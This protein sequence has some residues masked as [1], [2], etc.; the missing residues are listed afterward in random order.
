MLEEGP[1]IN[2]FSWIQLLQL[3]IAFVPDC[4]PT[5]LVPL[6]LQSYGRYPFP[7]LHSATSVPDK[8]VR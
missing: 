7:A 3:I 1:E 6:S 4:L 8:S 2:L 5:Y